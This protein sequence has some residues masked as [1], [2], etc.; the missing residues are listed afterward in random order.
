EDVKSGL[1]L[2]ADELLDVLGRDVVLSQYII[3]YSLRVSTNTENRSGALNDDLSSWLISPYMNTTSMNRS[4]RACR[5]RDIV[6][7]HP[8]TIACNPKVVDNNSESFPGNP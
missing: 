5:V 1:V 7:W 6:S 3:S 8:S 2:V 4:K